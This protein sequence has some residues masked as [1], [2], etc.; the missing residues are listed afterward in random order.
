MPRIITM[1][2]SLLNR[3]KTT[4]KVVFLSLFFMTNKF[5]MGLL[6]ISVKKEN[7]K[8]KHINGGASYV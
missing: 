1:L 2:K 7:T 5:I 3:K 4:V 6:H 8:I